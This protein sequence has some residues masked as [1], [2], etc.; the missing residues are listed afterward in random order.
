MWV[1]ADL[2]FPCDVEMV[3]ADLNTSR[4]RPPSG[5]SVRLIGFMMYVCE[6]YNLKICDLMSVLYL[7]ELSMMSPKFELS[8]M[9][10]KF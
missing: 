6:N 1:R 4:N 10:P 9:S 2:M 7:L 3:F 8:M 5:C